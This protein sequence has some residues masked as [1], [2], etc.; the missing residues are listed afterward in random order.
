MIMDENMNVVT[1]Q[2]ASVVTVS[3]ITSNPAVAKRFSDIL[4][5]KSAGFVSSLVSLSK[6]PALA[7][8]EPNSVV[9]SALVAAT[10]DLPIVPTLGFAAIV[11]FQNKKTGITVG[12]F[13]IMTKGLTQL[14]QRSGQYKTINVAPVY[15]GDIKSYNRFTGEI[16][17]NTENNPDLSKA[18]IGYVSYMQLTNGFEKYLYMTVEELKNHGLRF[19]KTM[20]KGYGLWV[21]NFDAMAKKT[22]L[23]L[24]LSKYGVLSVD[25]QMQLAMQADQAA[26][27]M[28][29]ISDTD[30]VDASM[31]YVD[32]ID[33][34][35]D[36]ETA[37][38]VAEKFKDF[39]A[40][41]SD[42]NSEDK[43]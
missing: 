28:E 1:Q 33:D 22:V 18:P 9:A 37:K 10:L 34:E 2:K 5:K 35:V 19:S 14:A 30:I 17:F 12:Q 31:E 43:K 32:N 38:K 8:A 23:K 42:G 40:T 36:D 39:D 3:S 4:G 16:V 29:S 24:L 41:I 27:R 20:K 21:E 7:K 13:Q 15:E 25:T 11:P 6:T 26:I